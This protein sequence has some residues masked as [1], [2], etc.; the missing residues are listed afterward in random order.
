MSP[1]K[2]KTDLSLPKACDQ[3]F[4]IKPFVKYEVVSRLTKVQASALQT[5]VDEFFYKDKV[6]ISK[7]F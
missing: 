7:D 2:D 4:K 3:I 5:F 1:N 6:V